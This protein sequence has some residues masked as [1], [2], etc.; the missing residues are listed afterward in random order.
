MDLSNVYHTTDMILNTL[1][2]GSLFAGFHKYRFALYNSKEIYLDGKLMPY[3]E[4]FRG[5]TSILYDDEFIAIWNLE[6][7]PIEDI[8]I[9]AYSLVHE[10]FHC[11][12]RAN[13]EKR[14]PSDL[15][16]LN[17]PDD[18]EN[19]LKKYNENRYL[20]EAYEQQDIEQF[21]KFVSIRNNRMNVYPDMVCQELR[22]ET[23]EGMAEY[24]GLKALRSINAEKFK[25]ITRNYVHKLRAEDSL[26]FDVRRISYYSGSI[27]FLCLDNFGFTIKNTFDSEQTVYEQSTIDTN[28]I[29]AEVYPFG[30]ISS[31]YSEFLKEKEAKVA[32][33]ISKSKYIACNAIICGYDPMNMFRIGN[34]IYCSHF[35]CLN[36]GGNIE[37]INSAIALRLA[38]N[39]N[40]EIIGYYII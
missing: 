24:V 27:Y 33:H 16:L 15:V 7:D 39:S 2:F 20:T 31:N 9:L 30:F 38:D 18:M 32:R 13:K 36:I 40:Q 12:Q 17:Y 26:M 6:L 25:I 22:T 29:V 3:Q 28:N 14:Y 35:I 19:F 34:I 4:G 11:H 8:E 21:K 10:M 37:S 1:D 23:L 5:N